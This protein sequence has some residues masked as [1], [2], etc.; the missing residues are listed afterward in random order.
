[1][2][3]EISQVDRDLVFYVVGIIVGAMGAILIWG[4]I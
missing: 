4:S 3:N 1:M 2:D